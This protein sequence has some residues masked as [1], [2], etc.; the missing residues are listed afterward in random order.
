MEHHVHFIVAASGRDV[1]DFVLHIY[2]SFAEQEPKLQEGPLKASLTL[3]LCN[4]LRSFGS[5]EQYEVE[6]RS[7]C[8]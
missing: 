8:R 3:E 4:S 6:D 7:L 1:D 5:A 2:A